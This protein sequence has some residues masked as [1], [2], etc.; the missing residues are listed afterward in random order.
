MSRNR[1]VFLL[2]AVLVLVVGGAY[3]YRVL[4]PQ[5]E[6]VEEPAPQTARVQRGDIM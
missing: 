3:Y 6:Q 2:L 4:R 1:A 5:A